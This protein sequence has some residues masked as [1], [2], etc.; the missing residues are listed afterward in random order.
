VFGRLRVLTMKMLDV[1]KRRAQAR[2]N[3]VRYARKILARDSR[4]REIKVRSKSPVITRA[5]KGR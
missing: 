1:E 3:W 5:A 4:K 2:I